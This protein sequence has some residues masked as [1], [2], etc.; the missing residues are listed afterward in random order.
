MAEDIL[1]PRNYGQCL[2]C[3]RKLKT[4]ES[5]LL[6]M[7]KTCYKKYM[8]ENTHKKLFELKGEQTNGND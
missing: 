4:E 3:G 2:R 1:D 7:G 6:G 8:T 5:R